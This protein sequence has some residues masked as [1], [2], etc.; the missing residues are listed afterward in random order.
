[1]IITLD[2]PAG[3]GK[4][5][6]AQL[7]AQKLGFFYI[8]SGYLY[9]SLA[10]ILVTEFG[11]DEQKL[12]A[13]D[14]DDVRSI[15]DEHNFVYEYQDGVVQIF[16]KGHEITHHLKTSQ[17]SHDASIIS[18][19]HQVRVFVALVQQ[20]FGKLHNLV[21]DGR[22][23]GTE[24]YPQAEFKFYVTASPE[25]RAQRLQADLIARGIDIMF[26]KV[27]MMTLD[28]DRRDMTRT[29]SPLK[30][31]DDALEIDTSELSVYQI[32]EFMLSVIQK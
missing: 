29:I 7:L 24:I 2:G 28:R 18:A 1:M 9:R 15:L 16:F 30:K 6:L 32:L 23:C 4:S 31:A 8:N 11:Y 12:Q 22:D 19:L 14:I 13:P 5:T 21:T 27:L 25:I 17:V 26:E 10:Y 3:S 20:K